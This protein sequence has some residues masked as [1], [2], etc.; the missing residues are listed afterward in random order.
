MSHKIHHKQVFPMIKI[1]NFH[2]WYN[3]FT[4]SLQFWTVFRLFISSWLIFI[5]CIRW[6]ILFRK[7]NV[8]INFSSPNIDSTI[9]WCQSVISELD[10]NPG[11]RNLYQSS[12][13][14]T[15]FMLISTSEFVLPPAFSF[16]FIIFSS[17]SSLFLF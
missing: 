2:S 6:G 1:D 10:L 9:L 11:L 5:W 15:S 17:E 7:Y 13:F 4:I 12:S 14:L 3:H 16:L 8:F